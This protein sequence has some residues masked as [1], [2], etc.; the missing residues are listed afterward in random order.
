MSFSY[1]SQDSLSINKNNTRD[2]WFAIDKVQHFMYSVFV[3]LGTQ[4]VLVNKTKWMNR[5]PYP[6]PLY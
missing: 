1:G 3:S 5:V 2:E 6:Y 4:Y